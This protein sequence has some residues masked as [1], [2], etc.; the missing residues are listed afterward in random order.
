MPVRNSVDPAA[1]LHATADPALICNC[2]FPTCADAVQATVEMCRRDHCET[3]D[4][5]RIAGPRACAGDFYGP[6][7]PTIGVTGKRF[8]MLFNS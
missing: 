4:P 7:P 2:S 1:I 3:P 8:S 6:A 5:Q